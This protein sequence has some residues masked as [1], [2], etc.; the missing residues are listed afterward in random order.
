MREKKDNRFWYVTATICFFAVL[1]YLCFTAYQ[2]NL[3]S[4]SGEMAATDS[5]QPITENTPIRQVFQNSS[6]TL[7]GISL[8][9]C[10][11]QQTSTGIV[12]V[13]LKQG[14][15]LLYTWKLSMRSIKDW[16]YVDFILPST[17]Q[18]TKNEEF[19]VWIRTNAQNPNKT[20]T[21]A[22]T[23]EGVE[24]GSLL[25]GEEKIE[26]AAVCMELIYE[27]YRS[28]LFLCFIVFICLVFG[29]IV[30]LARNRQRKMERIFLTLGGMFCFFY[31][32]VIPSGQG[33]EEQT[34]F[35]RAYE[36]AEGNLLSEAQ[37]KDEEYFAEVPKGF[38]SFPSSFLEEV[39]WFTLAEAPDGTEDAKLKLTYL[40]S[41]I[42]Y[43]PQ[44]IGVAIG[45]IF[46][47]QAYLLLLFGRIF[48]AEAFLGCGYCA[49]KWIPDYRYTFFLFLMM[50]A[51][52]QEAVTLSA[53]SIGN[54][55]CFLYLAVLF[56]MIK[57]ERRIH[58][59]EFLFVSGLILLMAFANPGLSFFSLLLFLLPKEKFE[60]RPQRR[61]WLV[62]AI[63]MVF[64]GTGL[65]K[66]ANWYWFDDMAMAGAAPG[67]YEG[68]RTFFENPF[69]YFQVLPKAI[70]IGILEAV[71][72]KMGEGN[73]TL[74]LFVIVF[75]CYLFVH[76]SRKETG[77]NKIN[78]GF[79]KAF[80]LAVA[81]AV[82]FAVTLFFYVNNGQSRG[83][84]FKNIKGQIFLPVLLLIGLLGNRKNKGTPVN[85][86][87][88]L[89]LFVAAANLTAFIQLAYF[90]F[91]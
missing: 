5:A 37:E 84:I 56:A 81:V 49:C 25:Y 29:I 23:N 79:Y 85:N 47:G 32:I 68:V 7:R 43:L 54:A 87:I 65:W 75:Y 34:H 33:K 42:G 67:I 89:Y 66:L 30:F 78:F 57:Q 60:T 11:F 77:V 86:S 38:V 1:I 20:I 80:F 72:R 2:T 44:A 91:L 53:A 76:T 31:L 58:L 71:G 22:L 82:V 61:L 15:G 45:R 17:Q 48:G 73:V 21:V 51:T 4:R 3:I 88:S 63:S 46:T 50:P 28:K 41:P 12:S 6:S 83:E 35:F 40:N 74:P 26:D 16:E 39:N 59:R 90:Y 62:L 64:V 55:L 52:L 9:F 13:E 70:G 69:A 24:N 10:N 27:N 18:H 14:D 19:E 36:I 8:Q